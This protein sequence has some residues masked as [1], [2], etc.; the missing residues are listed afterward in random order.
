MRQSFHK[1]N[2]A[3]LLTSLLAFAL[4]TACSGSDGDS[5][6]KPYKAQVIVLKSVDSATGS[7]RFGLET[8]EF[9]TMTNLDR[10]EGDYIRVYRGGSIVIKE[11][12]GSIVQPEKFSGGDAP[13][14]RY[15]VEN[16]V[17]IARDYSTLA[18][19]SAFYQLDTIFASM[20]ATVGVKPETFLETLGV[21]RIKVFFEPTVEAST[22]SGS[23]STS[24][25]LNAAFVP[26]AKQFLLFQRSPIESVPLAAN[27]QVLSHEF[28]HAIFD[29]SFF[30]G[31]TDDDDRFAE[32]WAISGLNEGFA[33][34]TSYAFTGSTNILRGSIDI[35]SMASERN[36]AKTTFD[37]DD[38]M[39][40]EEACSGSFYCVGTIF[41]RSMY[42]ARAA[43]SPSP[44]RAEFE[45]AVVEALKTTKAALA[46]QPS[47]ILPAKGG[48]S[49][50]D[51]GKAR[52][53]DGQVTG[54]FLNSLISV[55]PATYT[56]A[57]CDQFTSEFGTSGFPVEARTV[58]P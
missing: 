24:M 43:I 41:A 35:A 30:G 46:A 57:L 26:T 52:A 32:E 25:K 55:L 50:A 31:E 20:E 47:T 42:N 45:I 53:Y 9:Q 44:S 15:R 16:G 6:S 22:S 1:T 2:R 19:L 5:A 37:F 49:A 38:L 40:D 51:G 39:T 48:T 54:A 27:L 8:R 23:G 18:M 14:L 7:V 21:D 13:D 29:Y 11:V 34:L 56:S 3:T 33:D 36:F 17:V 58:C 12:K 10:L 28:G 4:G